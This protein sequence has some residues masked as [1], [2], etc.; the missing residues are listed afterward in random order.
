MWINGFS[1]SV[2]IKWDKSQN[3]SPPVSSQLPQNLPPATGADSQMS[4][5]YSDNLTETWCHDG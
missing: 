2:W 1:V 5:S 3:L 4:E